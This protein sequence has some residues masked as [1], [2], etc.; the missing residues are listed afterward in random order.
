MLQQCFIY[1]LSS[2][3]GQVPKVYFAFISVGKCI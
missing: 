3:F 2:V 1:M